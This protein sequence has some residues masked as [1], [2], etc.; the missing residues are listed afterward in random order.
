MKTLR[1][2]EA[3]TKLPVLYEILRYQMLIV[4]NRVSWTNSLKLNDSSCEFIFN[5]VCATILI[6]QEVK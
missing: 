3:F 4:Y 5:L 2:R 6:L 1:E